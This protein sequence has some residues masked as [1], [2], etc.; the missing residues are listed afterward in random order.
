MGIN[1][2][3]NKANFLDELENCP[4]ALLDIMGGVN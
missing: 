2:P 4:S 3:G 1:L